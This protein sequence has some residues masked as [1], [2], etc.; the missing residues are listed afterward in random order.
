MNAEQGIVRI[1]AITM[2]CPQTHRTARNDLLDPTPRI[3]PVMACVVD[4]G[5]FAKIAKM[6]VVAAAVSAQNPPTG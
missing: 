3:D 1:Q 2:R 4:M 5:I 6:M